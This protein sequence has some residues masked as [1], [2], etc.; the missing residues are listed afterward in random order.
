M[1]DL[2]NLKL[3]FSFQ[4]FLCEVK[5]S[6]TQMSIVIA[7]TGPQVSISQSTTV[8]L[9]NNPWARLMYYLSCVESVSQFDFKYLSD[10]RRY[11]ELD[12]DDKEALLTLVILFNPDDMKK[13]HV[14][15]QVA[16]C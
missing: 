12:T 14:F 8:S 15:F 16:G 4:F 7:Q 10:H 3:K 1:F 11:L 2:K 13:A 6:K 9:P 5:K